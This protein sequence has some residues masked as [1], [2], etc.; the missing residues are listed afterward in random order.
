MLASDINNPEFIGAVQ[1]PDAALIVEFY[2]R[3]VQNM[4][5][6]SKEGK[7]IFED[8]CYVRINVP[9]LKDMQVDRPALDEHSRRFPRQ[10]QHYLNRTRGDAREVGTPIAEWPQ[11]TR[12]QAE[13]FRG[14]KFFTIESVANASDVA[15]QNLGM[16]GGMAPHILRDKA[17][18]FLSV[19]AGTANAQH[20][21]EELARRDAE[22]AMLKEQMSLINQRLLQGAIPAPATAPVAA[23][24]VQAQPAPKKRGRPS[25]AELA[26]RAQ[27]GA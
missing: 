5:K 3:P 9:G 25:K 10:Y 6:S 18:A 22:I 19:A 24:Q 23:P 20:Q 14:L 26:A 17:K 8:I 7:P 12:S 15:I 4:F 16:I 21:A 1:N 2:D 11:I 27:Q 13:E